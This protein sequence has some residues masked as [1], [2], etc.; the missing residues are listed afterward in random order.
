VKRRIRILLHR[1]VLCCAL[2]CCAVLCCAVL[3]CAVLCRV[4]LSHALLSLGNSAA[5]CCAALRCAALRCTLLHC[6]LLCHAMLCCCF[7][8][9][10]VAI[11]GEGAGASPSGLVSPRILSASTAPIAQSLKGLFQRQHTPPVPLPSGGVLSSRRNSTE[12][13]HTSGAYPRH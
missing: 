5:L 10:H 6:A 9:H 13:A 2:L 1:C 4:I 3:C 12:Q 7:H 11:A 8:L